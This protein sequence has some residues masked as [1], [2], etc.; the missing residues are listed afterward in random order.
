MR[1]DEVVCKTIPIILGILRG[2][3]V[4]SVDVREL[5]WELGGALAM[6][7][8]TDPELFAWARS[9]AY[10]TTTSDMNSASSETGALCRA[11][12]TRDR[13]IALLRLQR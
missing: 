8:L 10:T 13:I 11:T 1:Y 12:V 5:F 2:E 7:E 6:L 4:M 9:T 3:T